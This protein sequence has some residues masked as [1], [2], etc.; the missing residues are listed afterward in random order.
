MA[1]CRQQDARAARDVR[2]NRFDSSKPEDDG[3]S[4]AGESE[5]PVVDGSCRETR[6]NLP[7]VDEGG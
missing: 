3:A 6:S 5:E 4:E 1:R 7:G 2:D